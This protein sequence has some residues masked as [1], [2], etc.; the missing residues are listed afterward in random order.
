MARKDLIRT[1]AS[2][3]GVPAGEFRTFAGG[4]A[5]WEDRKTVSGAGQTERARGGRKKVANVTIMREDDGAF[6]FHALAQAR[7]VSMTVTRQPLDDDLNAFGKSWTY[8]GKAVS[9][10]PGEGDAEAD[11]DGSDATVEMSCDG[12]IT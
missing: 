6:D 2:F 5:T 1:T 7:S 11:S 4:D 8:T 12:L 9:V 10:V 3:N